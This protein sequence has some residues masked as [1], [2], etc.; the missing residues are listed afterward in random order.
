MKRKQKE[1][2]EE[3]GKERYF[4]IYEKKLIYKNK[5]IKIY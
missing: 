5:I 2:K 4:E 3:N 1:R